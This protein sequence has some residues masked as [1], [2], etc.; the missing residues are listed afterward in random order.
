M[1]DFPHRPA[2]VTV[3]LAGCAA[4]IILLAACTSSGKPKAAASGSA[5]ARATGAAGTSASGDARPGLGGA[6]AAL[7]DSFTAAPLEPQ[8]GGPAAGCLRSDKDYPFLVAAAVHPSSF[9]NVSCVSAST[10]DL[11][12]SER[13]E[14]EQRPPQLDA[15]SAA[16]ALVTVQVGGDDIGVG[17]IATTCGA[18]SFTDPLASPCEKHYTT[19]GTDQ[20]ARAV[21]QAGPKV[22]AVLQA[23]RQRAPHARILLVGYPDI[24]PTSGNGCWPEVTIARGDVPYLRGV[25][26]ELNAMLATEA[27]RGGATFVDTYTPSIGHDACQRSGVKWV[28]GLIPTSIALPFHPNALGEQ[29]M[30]REVLAA[31][32]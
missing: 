19:G 5:T 4:L 21:A 32:H 15:L 2:P 12:H 25:E 14:T 24:L 16:D 29:A 9:T 28:E 1:A 17:H 23:I 30:A 8:Q 27:A 7:G 31:L 20:L 6:Y 10:T 3:L 22:A 18:L 11:S 26:H 13:T